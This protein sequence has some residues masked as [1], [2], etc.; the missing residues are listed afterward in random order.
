MRA[1]LLSGSLGKGHDTLVAACARSLESRGHATATLDAMALLGSRG[2]R[3]GEWVFRR[4]LGR[5]A[6]YDALHFGAL[7]PGGRLAARMEGAALH[8]LVPR[9]TAELESFSP[10]LV[11]SAFPTGAAAVDRVKADRPGL[12]S[13]VFNTDACSHR[14]WVHDRTDLFLVT[15]ELSAATVRRYRPGAEVIV[16]PA[17]V[18]PGFAH[19]PPRDEARARLG[20]PDDATCVLVMSGAWGLGP[21]AAAVAAL[22]HDDHHVL[23]VAGTNGRLEA[24]LRALAEGDRRVHPFGFTHRIPELMS[25]AD[26]VVT[27]SGDTCAEARVVGRP[28]VVLDVVPGHGRENVIHELELGRAE[29]CSPTPASVRGAV[30]AALSQ[31]VAAAPGGSQ[32]PEW[33]DAFVAALAKIG[34]DPGPVVDGA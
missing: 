23:A 22:A 14:L 5:P 4:L 7:V 3:L 32:G 12:V 8:R 11:L 19:P 27:T 10:G 21:V 33:E 28:L 20:V 25:A 30:A 6:V 16:V 18:R 26:V 24:R 9:L 34:V 1:L 29:V 15:S 17:P 13:V 31:P 2:H